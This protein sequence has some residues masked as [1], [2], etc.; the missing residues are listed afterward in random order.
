MEIE[1]MPSRI[2]FHTFLFAFFNPS[3]RQSGIE[4]GVSRIGKEYPVAF[5]EVFSEFSVF[6]NKALLLFRIA[7]SK[8]SFRFFVNKTQTMEKW[9]DA[10]FRISNAKLFFY[11]VT[12]FVRT[13]VKVFLKPK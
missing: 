11:E 7:T 1:A 6:A 5:P 9:D 8:Y 12:N 2:G 3:K 10:F 13:L 4:G